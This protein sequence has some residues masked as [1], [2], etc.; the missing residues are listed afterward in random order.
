MCHML[1]MHLYRNALPHHIF[2]IR[3]N[4]SLRNLKLNHNIFNGCRQGVRV[5]W[6]LLS[7]PKCIVDCIHMNMSLQHLFDVF[8]STP[9]TLATFLLLQID[10]PKTN[11]HTMSLATTSWVYFGPTKWLVILD[12]MCSKFLDFSW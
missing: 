8:L 1:F 5:S 11:I 7:N 4:H 3:K 2:S 9:N 10:E 12:F 6:P